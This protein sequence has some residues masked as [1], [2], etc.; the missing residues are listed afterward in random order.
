MYTV[1]CKADKTPI[2]N[3]CTYICNTCSPTDHVSATELCKCCHTMTST[4]VCTY[5]HINYTLSYIMI[6]ITGDSLPVRSTCMT[7]LFC[8]YIY[9]YHKVCIPYSQPRALA[10]WKKNAVHTYQQCAVHTIH[11]MIG[12]LNIMYHEWRKQT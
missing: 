2:P 10:Q 1:D 3:K 6:Q 7:P 4:Y 9:I 11:V 5:T 8:I 12:Y